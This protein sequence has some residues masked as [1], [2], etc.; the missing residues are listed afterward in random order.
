[1]RAY[2]LA[3]AVVLG[4]CS[5]SEHVHNWAPDPAPDL[6]Q[7][8][9][10]RIVAD[11]IWSVFKDQNQMSIG[12]LEIS[13]V[14]PVDHLNGPAWVTCLKL[15]AH[16]NSPQHYAI[17]IQENKII[18]SRLGIL[19]DRCH[20]EAYTPFEVARPPKKSNT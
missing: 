7:P 10:R 1:V 4:S 3:V 20:K 19:I 17:F 9:Y 12:A 6:S 16:G 8:N 14:R 11:N 13:G 2:V 15:D 18:D 5:A